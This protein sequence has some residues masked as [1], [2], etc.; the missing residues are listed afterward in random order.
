MLDRLELKELSLCYGKKNLLENLSGSFARGQLNLIVGRAGSGKS[1]LLRTLAGFHQDFTGKILA[2]DQ[3]FKADGNIS[4]AFQNPETLFFN[5]SVGEEVAFALKMR[6]IN[7]QERDN[8]S[9][10]WLSRWGLAPDRYWHDHPLELSG[11]EKRRLALAA[12]TIFMPPVILLDEPLAGLDANGQ[13]DLAEMLAGMSSDHIVIVVTHEP[14]I[15]LPQCGVL[16]YLHEGSGNWFS[17]SD[18]LRR[19]LTDKTFFPLPDW[20]FKAVEPFREAENLPQ[21]K[22]DAV[23][24][25]VNRRGEN[26]ADKL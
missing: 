11:G 26:H 23:Y 7:Q 12:C 8:A 19:A 24:S 17:P 5:G 14:E 4:L 6:N 15:L 2:D 16:L 20:Y 3:L 25:F 1:T 10:D 21:L 22:A 9:R 18:F 13:R